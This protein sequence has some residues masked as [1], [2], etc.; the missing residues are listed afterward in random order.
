MMHR[1]H[2]RSGAVGP[3]RQQGMVMIVVLV[4]ISMMLTVAAAGSRSAQQ[5]S[6]YAAYATDRELAFAA[7]DAALADGEADLSQGARAAQFAV[8]AEKLAGL[9]GVYAGPVTL[10]PSMVRRGRANVQWPAWR[11]ANWDDDAAVVAP[12]TYTGGAQPP[13]R[14]NVGGQAEPRPAASARYLIERLPGMRGLYRMTARGRGRLPG[15]V[16][17]LQSTYRLPMRAEDAAGRE[18]DLWPAGRLSWREIVA[19]HVLQHEVQRQ[20]RAR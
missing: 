14:Q 13:D 16:V 15:T 7:A 8:P 2:P 20:G 17:Y 9:H 11:V 5:A 6:R 19:W 4:L 1:P 12:G 18:A 10:P 3:Q